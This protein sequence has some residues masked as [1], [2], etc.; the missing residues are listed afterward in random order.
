VKIRK[1]L[2][3]RGGQQPGK[4]LV[5]HPFRRGEIHNPTN[6]L[7]SVIDRSYCFPFATTV[8]YPRLQR[9]KVKAVQLCGPNPRHQQPELQDVVVKTAL[10]LVL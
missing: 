6:N 3:L 9:A 1:Q 8:L 7:Q 10:V 5:V 2:D 4:P